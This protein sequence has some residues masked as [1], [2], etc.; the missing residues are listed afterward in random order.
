MF[1]GYDQ[2]MTQVDGSFRVTPFYAVFDSKTFEAGPIFRPPFMGGLHLVDPADGGLTENWSEDNVP[3]LERGHILQADTFE[4]L[5][6]KINE[7]GATDGYTLDPAALAGTV[8]SYNGYCTEG[9]D[10]DFGLPAETSQAENLV[11]LDTPPYYCAVGLM[12][13]IYNTAGGPRK[14]AKSQAMKPG[15]VPIPPPVRRRRLQR[16]GGPN[17]HDIRPEL[18]RDRELRPHRRYQRRSR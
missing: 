1:N 4:E 7:D 8:A 14:N 2:S 9:I 6:E 10:P 11:P 3:E 17:L 12:P 16:I 18:G 15:G 13:S 5:A